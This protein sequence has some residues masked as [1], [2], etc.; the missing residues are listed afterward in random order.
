MRHVFEVMNDT[1]TVLITMSESKCYQ[2]ALEQ[3][4][5]W[6]VAMVLDSL[7]HKEWVYDK[8]CDFKK[9]YNV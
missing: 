7:P 2:K 1:D 9:E 6:I 8:L 5:P 3:N 4:D